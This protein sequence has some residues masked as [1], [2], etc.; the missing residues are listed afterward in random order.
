MDSLDEHEMRLAAEALIAQATALS[1][2]GKKW[3]AEQ[4]VIVAE[5]IW[6]IVKEREAKWI[7]QRFGEVKQA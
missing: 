7:A 6:R 5:K 3:D 2:A 4:R 1:L